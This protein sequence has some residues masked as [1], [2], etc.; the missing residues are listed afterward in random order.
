MAIMMMLIT[1]YFGHT[2]DDTGYT[3]PG[4]TQHIPRDCPE[5][6]QG[7]QYVYGVIDREPREDG[8]GLQRR[9][10]EQAQARS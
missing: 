10:C 4:C 5:P 3:V 6:Q 8:A 2:Y 1:E 7:V 9:I